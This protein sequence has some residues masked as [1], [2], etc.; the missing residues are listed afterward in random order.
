MVVTGT[1]VCAVGS[2]RTVDDKS[3]YIT[4]SLREENKFMGLLSEKVTSANDDGTKVTYA[5]CPFC[6]RDKSE[7][8]A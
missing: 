2:L 3:Y 4:K 5:A 8:V 6:T 7:E 1:K